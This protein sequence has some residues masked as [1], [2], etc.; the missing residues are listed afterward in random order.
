MLFSLKN[1]PVNPFTILFANEPDHIAKRAPNFIQRFNGWIGAVPFDFGENARRDADDLLRIRLLTHTGD[2]AHSTNSLS[3]GQF[4]VI[5]GLN[6]LP[7]GKHN[8]VVVFQLG[9]G[10]SSECEQLPG[11]GGDSAYAMLNDVIVDSAF[12]HDVG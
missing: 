1:V 9:H 3:H 4:A 7:L 5:D 6:E 11:V 2:P 12:A 8:I 10:V